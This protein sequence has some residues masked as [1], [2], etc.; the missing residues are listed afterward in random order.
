[1]HPYPRKMPS[2]VKT[3]ILIPKKLNMMGLEN[4]S[5]TSV[6]SA[7]GSDLSAG[8]DSC[9]IP[10]GSPSSFSSDHAPN[11]GTVFGSDE[12]SCTDEDIPLVLA[13][14]ILDALVIRSFD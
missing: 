11:S 8:V 4:Q 1:M 12:N 7:V 9:I 10:N 3:E 13:P 5:P 14:F 6:L 2:P